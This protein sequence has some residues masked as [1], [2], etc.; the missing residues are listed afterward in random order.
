MELRMEKELMEFRLLWREKLRGGASDHSHGGGTFV[1]ERSSGE[2]PE[3]T[4]IQ[5]SGGHWVNQAERRSARG[6]SLADINSWSVRSGRWA[7]RNVSDQ[8]IAD[9]R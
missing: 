7:S 8:S 4:P 5:L 9:W 6:G 2:A 3:V 1:Q